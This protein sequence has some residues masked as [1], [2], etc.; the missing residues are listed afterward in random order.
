MNCYII[1][2]C[3]VWSFP[4][5]LAL[6]YSNNVKNII[7]SG[8]HTPYLFVGLLTGMNPPQTRPYPQPI[9]RRGSLNPPHPATVATH[10]P[11]P[12]FAGCVMRRCSS[13]RRAT[14]RQ[15]GDGG[16]D[17]GGC[18]ELGQCCGD[19]RSSHTQTIKGNQ[20]SR[21]KTKTQNKGQPK[22]LFLTVDF[23]KVDP[24]YKCRS[25]SFYREVDG[26]FTFR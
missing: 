15:G 17:L 21:T 19:S 20:S 14:C 1:M 18:G 11:H 25:V 12:I 6:S 4:L 16:R 10:P 22:A 26:L 2:I 5:A 8:V 13:P 3:L 9:T 23:S 24:L 7:L